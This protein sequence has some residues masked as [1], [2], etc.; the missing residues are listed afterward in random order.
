MRD[1]GNIHPAHG[2]L[3]W[4]ALWVRDVACSLDTCSQKASQNRSRRVLA[5]CPNLIS[6]GPPVSSCLPEMVEY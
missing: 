6:V 1:T 5:H 4:P 3:V 2:Y